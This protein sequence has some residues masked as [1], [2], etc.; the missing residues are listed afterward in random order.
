MRAEAENTVA[1]IE[2]SLELLAQRMDWE[3]APHRLEE[4]NA[5]TEDPNLWDD[6]EKAQKLMRD[7]QMLVDAIAAL[8]SGE[9]PAAFV[10]ASAIG[11]YG[12]RRGR[13]RFL[14]VLT[15]PLPPSAAS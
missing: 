4:F 8:P 15:V 3:T 13:P 14:V 5:M 9:R 7:R 1:A 11:V 2:K 10:S 12:E 6:P